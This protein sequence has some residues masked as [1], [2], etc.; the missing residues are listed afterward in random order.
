MSLSYPTEQQYLLVKEWFSNHQEIYSWGGP[1]MTFPM[2]DE[3]YLKHLTANH[4]K[5][6]CLLNNEQQLVAFGQYYRL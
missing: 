5:S 2:S 6:F 1:N 3:N 4:L